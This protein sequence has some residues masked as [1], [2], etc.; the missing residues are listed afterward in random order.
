MLLVM[1]VGIA[2][3]LEGCGGGSSS[4]RPDGVAFTPPSY[5]DWPMFGRDQNATFYAPQTQITTGNVRKLGIAWSTSLGPEQF[6]V[7]GYPVES[8]GTVYI[9][10]SSDEVQAYD[11]ATGKRKWQ[12]APRVDFSQSTG[13]G[14]YGVT[15][16]RGVAMA[17]G[18]VFELSFDDHLRAISAAS[19]EELWSTSVVSD[20]TGAYETMAPSVADGLVFV[21]VSGS[22]DGIRGFV[23]AYNQ[24]TGKQVW[25]FYTVPAAGHGWVPKNGGGAGVYMPPTVDPRTGLVYAGTSTPAPVIY[26]VRRKGPDL[27]SDSILALHIK[28]GKLDWY[29]QEV[30]HDLWDYGADSPV[31]LFDLIRHGSTIPALAEAGKDGHVYVLNA[32]T[33][34]QLYAPAAYVKEHHPTPT[35][36]GTLVCPGSVGG[37]PYS[38]LALDPK[39]NA[40]YVSGVNLC[41][42]LKVE[43]TV[44]QGEKEF[45]GVRS[46]PDNETPT[47]TFDAINLKTGG[48]LWKR[49]MATPM[50]GGAAATAG[51]LVFTGDQHGNFYALDAATGKTLWKTNVGLAFGS[52]PIVYTDHGTEFVAVA[53]GGSATTAANHL[54]P[55]GARLDVFKLGGKP[56]AAARAR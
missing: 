53:V 15:T 37:S 33:G 46:T 47:G 36:Q 21:G 8:H 31:M 56:V 39:Q 26:G 6:L 14:G 43:P 42:V 4:K 55:T 54:G 22:Q 27:Y 5:Q 52:A 44:A 38:P 30:P 10:T 35:R 28:T 40:A 3:I 18:N 34:K 41:Q 32:Q 24:R 16:N 13:V 19:G 49:K 23:A 51:N 11:A 29:H 50:V 17:D 48:F 7:E 45:A 12:Y 1:A 20:S 25:R 9:T 2:P